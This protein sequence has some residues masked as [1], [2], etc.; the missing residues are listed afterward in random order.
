MDILPLFTETDGMLIA[1]KESMTAIA[2][3]HARGID[4]ITISY[5]DTM[6]ETSGQQGYGVLRT[7]GGATIPPSSFM[8]IDAPKVDIGPTVDTICA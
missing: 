8:G 5:P 7:I 1:Y 3:I 2:G 4:F 6:K